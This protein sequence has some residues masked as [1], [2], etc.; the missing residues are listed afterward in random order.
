VNKSF[1]AANCSQFSRKKCFL[2]E[3][4][5]LRDLLLVK[6]KIAVSGSETFCDDSKLFES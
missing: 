2:L 3:T 5:E 1:T 4:E 6:N